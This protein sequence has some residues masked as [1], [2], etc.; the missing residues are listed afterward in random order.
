MVPQSI[1]IYIYIYIH[2]SSTIFL[3]LHDRVVFLSILNSP[4]NLDPLYKTDLYLWDCLGRV[5]LI[6][7]QKF[8][9]L[10]ESFV[11]IL[12]RGK[13]SSYSRINTVMHNTGPLH[14]VCPKNISLRSN[15]KCITNFTLDGILA[16]FYQ[17]RRTKVLVG[18]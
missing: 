9:G 12:E 2:T 8:I 14:T 15:R 13:P 5:K 10:I 17:F 16:P 6:V 3:P 1:Y 4:K 7:Y 18:H 11:V